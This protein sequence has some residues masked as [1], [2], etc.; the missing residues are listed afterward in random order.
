MAEQSIISSQIDNIL[1]QRKARAVDLRRR[2]EQV[3][4]LKLALTGCNQ[5]PSKARSIEDARLRKEC[6]DTLSKVKVP[7]KVMKQTDVILRKM[8]ETIKRFERESLNIAT[9]GK[10]RQGKSTILQAISNL[11]NDIIPA[12]DA[13]D[14]T[15]AVSIIHNDSS[16][17]P[18]RV[19]VELTFR[20]QE[21]LLNIV[22]GYINN[23]D[24]EYLVQNPLEYGE[25]GYISID[26][27]EMR[28][29]EGE[30]G[31]MVQLEH[32]RR[33]VDDFK[34]ISDSKSVSIQ[35]LCGQPA[36]SLTNPDE[37]RKY[38]AQN[39]GKDIT[40]PL[41]ENYYSYLAVNKAEIY[42]HFA[43]D[44]GKLVLVDTIGLG[45]TQLGIEEAMLDTV[46]KQCDATIVVT[47]P[48]SGVTTQ[49]MSIYEML[50]QHFKHRDMKKWLF[51]VAN[52]HRGVN[53]NVASTFH[54]GIINN[55]KY[56][57]ADCK[58]IDGSD[59]VAVRQDFL[60][61]MLSKLLG[62]LEHV[63]NLFVQE[64]NKLCADLRVQI[65][66]MV[67][68]F[69]NGELG[70]SG[71]PENLHAY[72]L[73]VECYNRLTSNL[74]KQVQYWYEEQNKPNATLWNRVKD[75][76]NGLEDILP[77]EENLQ[78]VLDQSG[79]LK[80]SAL[81]QV[82]L[83]YV[84]NEISDQFISLDD[85]MGEETLLFKNTLVGE[86]YDSLK[87]MGGLDD[88]PVE[89][90]VQSE[91]NQTDTNDALE[92]KEEKK[93]I[94]KT[95]WLWDMM[96]PMLRDNPEYIQIYRAF[97]F[98]D[99]FNFNIRAQIIQEVRYQLR[100]INDMTTDFYMKPNYTFSKS[101]AGQ[102]VHFY[103]TSRLAI[104]EDGLRESLMKMNKMPNQ[105]F[106]AAA[107]E[108][109][110]RLTFASDFKNDRFVNMANIWGKFFSQYS[111]LIWKKEMEKQEAVKRVMKEYKDYCDLLAEKLGVLPA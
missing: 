55:P 109:Y 4:E 74:D 68:S 49:D 81:W 31:K 107:E 82:P 56:S 63:D 33:I 51:Y 84:R 25:I 16:M 13:G 72:T 61:P 92:V 73:G 91:Q 1:M 40:D 94:D 46:D 43:D 47:K 98:L 30:A 102:A 5:L 9:V 100:I 6:M 41:R 35:D 76:L 29:E 57:I 96:E 28:I 36:M 110:D 8:D 78:R 99:Q 22:K 2:R 101:N 77:S 58:L 20:S 12:F 111:G 70:T 64:I 10:A 103:M 67:E 79:D 19:R 27:L 59:S 21:E 14:C 37:I 32:L 18:G 24:P 15:G 23:I 86:L 11:G 80:E 108:F 69:P 71:G 54:Q 44:V 90:Q 88:E 89:D 3:M 75:I 106:Y 39:N 48:I 7:M 45:D 38:V 105:A 85:L 83:N 95:R 87:S 34:G 66:S 104:L 42:C 97:Q 52:L 93:E 53:D 62:N 65:Q 17:E 26:E 60:L 50:Q